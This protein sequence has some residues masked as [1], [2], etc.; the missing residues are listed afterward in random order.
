MAAAVGVGSGWR[1]TRDVPDVGGHSWRPLLLLRDAAARGS[2]GWSSPSPDVPTVRDA[3]KDAVGRL[4]Y[5]R[6]EGWTGALL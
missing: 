5:R 1:R 3:V 2:S 4:G 6:T